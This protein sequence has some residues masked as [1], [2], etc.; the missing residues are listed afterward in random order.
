V[1]FVILM[2]VFEML[3]KEPIQEIG[4]QALIMALLLMYVTIY[5]LNKRA[6]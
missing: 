5:Y 1:L 3:G 2:S 4:G 6:R